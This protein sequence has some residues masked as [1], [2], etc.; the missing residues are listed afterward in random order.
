MQ[1]KD[2]LYKHVR[3]QIAAFRDTSISNQPALDAVTVDN[4]AS[5]ICNF[6]K[7]NDKVTAK[8]L[9]TP[10]KFVELLMEDDDVSLQTRKTILS[11]MLSYSNYAPIRKSMRVLTIK[12]NALYD[13]RGY[14]GTKQELLKKSDIHKWFD[15]VVEGAVNKA[16]FE[17]FL[18][19]W[20]LYMNPPRR[21]GAYS[22]SAANKGRVGHKYKAMLYAGN[23]LSAGTCNFLDLEEM[24]LILNTY[25]TSKVYGRVVIALRDYKVYN[26]YDLDTNLADSLI[27][28]YKEKYYE[29]G[30]PIFKWST[31]QALKTLK[32]LTNNA[33]NFNVTR[34][35]L[36]THYI[37]DSRR[38]QKIS[39]EMGHTLRTHLGVY[40][41]SE[42]Y[43]QQQKVK[44][45][46]LVG[47][48]SESEDWPPY[49]P[50][51]TRGP[52]ESSEYSESSE[53]E[54]ES[55]D[56]RSYGTSR[57]AVKE[58]AVPEARKRLNPRP[59]R[60]VQPVRSYSRRYM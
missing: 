6:I 43:D 21:N 4:Y 22:L 48:S 40:L 45:E 55:D 50:K 53:S 35:S 44:E 32:K 36:A 15:N 30:K 31:G 7:Q 8:T 3:E 28:E 19:F 54:S 59:R 25:K 16:G 27:N 37:L 49:T 13:K 34:K 9:R 47:E 52:A 42:S 57:N 11:A 33:N 56:K 46:P 5:V 24:Q 26:V 2:R 38:M 60:R 58:P 14:V 10:K 1:N 51:T 29:M 18:L 41:L 39:Y 17:R 12:I 23:D 20:L